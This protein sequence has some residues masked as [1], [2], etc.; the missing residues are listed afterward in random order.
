MTANEKNGRRPTCR[1]RERRGNTY[2]NDVQKKGAIL[3][4]NRGQFHD[5]PSKTKAEGRRINNHV[6]L[7]RAPAGYRLLVKP[8]ARNMNKGGTAGEVA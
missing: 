5:T 6:E 1:K 3:G 2:E 4:A 7:I 8:K